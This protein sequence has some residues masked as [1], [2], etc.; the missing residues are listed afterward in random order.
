MLH[1]VGRFF[2]GRTNS[3]CVQ[4]RIV[5][6]CMLFFELICARLATAGSRVDVLGTLQHARIPHALK[7]IFLLIDFYH[8]LGY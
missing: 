2:S 8:H 1:I 5:F 7:S 4:L 6:T 3:T